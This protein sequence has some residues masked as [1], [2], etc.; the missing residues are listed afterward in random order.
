MAD[1]TFIQE[2]MQALRARQD[3][4]YQ[5]THGSRTKLL[6]HDIADALGD[7]KNFGRIARKCKIYGEHAARAALAEVNE[8]QEVKSPAALWEY[9]LKTK[10]H[11]TQ[12]PDGSISGVQKKKGEII[13]GRFHCN[14][15]GIRKGRSCS[16]CINGRRLRRKIREVR[17]SVGPALQKRLFV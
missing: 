9:I 2:Y 4:K 5:R 3:G 7:S 6:A 14:T 17:R 12:Q 13:D 16:D 11:A 10:Y 1:N 15:H 8:S